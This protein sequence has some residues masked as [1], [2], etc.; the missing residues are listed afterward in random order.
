M[1]FPH[2]RPDS[3]TEPFRDRFAIEGQP[4]ATLDHLNDAELELLQQLA[5]NIADPEMRARVADVIW[6]RKRDAQC[7][8]LAIDAYLE[9]ARSL[10]PET[11]SGRR[12]A[13]TRDCVT[14][15]KGL[16]VWPG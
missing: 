8:Q 16:F 11:A 12:S 9:S 15:S 6:V 2:L 5:P 3:V 14:A 10:E 1:T 13:N 7:A 4:L